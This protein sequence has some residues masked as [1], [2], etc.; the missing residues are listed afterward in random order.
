MTW[1]HVEMYGKASIAEQEAT[2]ILANRL[3]KTARLESLKFAR[4]VL[5]MWKVADQR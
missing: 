3:R 5:D 2:R 1:W 4:D